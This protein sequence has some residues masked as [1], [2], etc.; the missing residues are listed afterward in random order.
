LRDLANRAGG[1]FDNSSAVAASSSRPKPSLGD[2][3]L[4]H[5]VS[6][7][8]AERESARSRR[9]AHHHRHGCLAFDGSRR[10]A[11]F[12]STTNP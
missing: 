10:Q 5:I 2:Y 7:I 4:V 1:F 3:E 9:M 8:G 11:E 12:A 6:F